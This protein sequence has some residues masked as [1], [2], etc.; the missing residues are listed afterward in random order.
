MLYKYKGTALISA[1]K[2]G[3]KDIVKLLLEK[4]ANIKAKDN[5]K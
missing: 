2:K 5:Y 1:A 3:F 4:G